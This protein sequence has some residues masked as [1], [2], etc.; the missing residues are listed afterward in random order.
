MYIHVLLM[1][2]YLF[3]FFHMSKKVI[4]S[5]SVEDLEV[6]SDMAT[7]LLS[8]K[9]KKSVSPV[10]DIEGYTPPDLFLCTESVVFSSEELAVL[11]KLKHLHVIE[12][13]K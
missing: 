5:L 10:H 12:Y 3:K 11:K 7:Y 13:G 8:L 9:A 6:L 4:S 2:I 1:I